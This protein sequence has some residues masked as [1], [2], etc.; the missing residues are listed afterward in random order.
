MPAARDPAP[1]PAC[2]LPGWLCVCAYAPRVAIRTPLLLLVHVRE[3]GQASNTARLLALAVRG[4][5]LVC[6][7]RLPAPPDPASY[8]PAGATPAVLFPGR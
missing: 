3:W 8:L 7:G 1:C 4:T 6:H 5:T 2:R